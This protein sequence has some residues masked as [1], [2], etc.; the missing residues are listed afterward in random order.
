MTMTFLDV[1]SV[2]GTEALTIG[3]R[4]NLLVKEISLGVDKF[5][6][7]VLNKSIHTVDARAVTNKLIR[8][9]NYFNV[10]YKHIP[11][12]V[13]FNPSSCTFR[14][15]MEVVTRTGGALNLVLSQAEDLYRGLKEVAAKG[16]ISHSI[17][18]GGHLSLITAFLDD[19]KRVSGKS[20]V[21]TRAISELYPNWTEFSRIYD[22][23]NAKVKLIQS[24]D[25]EVVAKQ[26]DQIVDIS[27]LV[28]RKIDGNEIVL[29]PED[30]SFLNETMTMM[31]SNLKAVGQGLLQL[32][33]LTSILRAH[34]E[35][36]GKL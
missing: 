14:E 10:S 4:I 24:R 6:A 16:T 12:P 17:R 31:D 22:D 29:S 34:V 5:N 19:L 33:E 25:A 1:H 20:D 8:A 26:V 9:N 11:T 13:L 23:F 7:K 32:G 15:Y 28:K 27:K 30:F 18:N 21:Q 35:E 36:L 3:E 2:A